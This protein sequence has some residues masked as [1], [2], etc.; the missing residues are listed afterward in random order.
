[1]A[2]RKRKK[3][4]VC[5]HKFYFYD[6]LGGQYEIAAKVIPATESVAPVLTPNHVRRSMRLKGRGNSQTCSGSICMIENKG[7]FPHNVVGYSDFTDVRAWIMSK[8][9]PKKGGG[10]N[11]EC[12][13]YAHSAG[14]LSKANDRSGGAQ[15]L[16]A[17]LEAE[18]GD[19]RTLHLR[20]MPKAQLKLGVYVVR[21]FRTVGLAI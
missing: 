11:A 13:Q 8:W 17:D 20:P 2:Q 9:E 7:L 4:R 10:I 16:L 6:D 12:V 14:W 19:G 15:S 3:F 5:K 21:A 18:G 1:V